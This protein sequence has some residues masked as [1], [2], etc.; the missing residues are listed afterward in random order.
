MNTLRMN[1]GFAV[2]LWISL[3]I[4]FLV[5]SSAT[6]I[7]K[8]KEVDRDFYAPVYK[9]NLVSLDKP[10]PVK[11]KKSKRAITKKTATKKKVSAP[12]V[13]TK[14]A[15]KTRT[16]PKKMVATVKPETVDTDAA[17]AAL[18]RDMEPTIAVE[19]IREKLEQELAAEDKS[20][21][22]EAEVTSSA[23]KAGVKKVNV[24]E[25]DKALQ[26]YYDTVWEKIENSWVL[27]GTGDFS[28]MTSI[29]S[30]IISASG[31]LREVSIEEGSGNGFYD[32][33]AIRAVRK[34]TPF[35]PLP[36]GYNKGME[37]GFRFKQ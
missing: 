14:K 1:N 8:K 5:L 37:I 30:V 23:L 32:Q 24:R 29:V 16:S 10:K 17:I 11:I 25:M 2:W 15:V 9:V 4:H 34:A 28:G 33:S 31:Q 35:P 26:D 22:K 18:R 36:A 21:T 19:R 7:S 13:T 27:P 6:Y 3:F 12:A 20:I